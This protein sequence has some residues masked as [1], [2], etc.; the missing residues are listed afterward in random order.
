ML[1]KHMA[2]KPDKKTGIF[3]VGPETPSPPPSTPSTRAE[4][5]ARQ[6]VLRAKKPVVAVG[7]RDRRAPCGVAGQ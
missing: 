1:P 2:Q 7:P 6:E 4:E 5:S 3:F